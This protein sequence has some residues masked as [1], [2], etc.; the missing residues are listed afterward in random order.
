MRVFENYAT[1]DLISQ[2]RAELVVG[3]GSSVEAFPLFGLDLGDYDEL[4]E[5]FDLLLL[6]TLPL[7]AGLPAR[8]WR[9]A[10]TPGSTWT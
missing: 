6:P 8:A 10:T 1:L 5:E 3:R 7:R 9:S 4:F 2:G